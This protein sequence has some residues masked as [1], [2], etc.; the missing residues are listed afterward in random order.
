MKSAIL[1]P[2]D[3]FLHSS[4]GVMCSLLSEDVVN[5]VLFL[6]STSSGSQTDVM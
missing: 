3:W 1:S 6:S 5:E 2:F 4:L